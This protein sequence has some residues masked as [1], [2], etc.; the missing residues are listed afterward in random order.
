MYAMGVGMNAI[1]LACDGGGRGVG[2]PSLVPLKLL[3]FYPYML[4]KLIASY[5]TFQPSHLPGSSFNLLYLLYTLPEY[6]TRV[7]TNHEV[8]L[9]V[10]Y[11]V[12]DL[13]PLLPCCLYSVG[14][15]II[16]L[17]ILL[18]VCPFI[19]SFLDWLIYSETK[20]N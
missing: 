19:C 9:F 14:P 2:T 5:L 15:F 12:C 20:N 1:T 6:W 3:P 13:I 11:F 10:C 18:S 17:S 4:C 16:D 8:H 7:Q